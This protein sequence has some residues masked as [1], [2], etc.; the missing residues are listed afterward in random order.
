MSAL[1]S[2]DGSGFELL[3]RGRDGPRLLGRRLLTTTEPL[4]PLPWERQDGESAAAYKIFRV[5]LTLGWG[6][7]LEACAAEA[8]RSYEHV[9]RTARDHR[10]GDR[11]DAYESHLLQQ[12]AAQWIERCLRAFE[13][14]ASLLRLGRAKIAEA[15]KPAKDGG[16][17]FESAKVGD[18]VRLMDVVLRQSRL[19]YGD[20]YKTL[21]AVA[22]EEGEGPDGDE[23]TERF[24]R[25]P[26]S[27]RD[28]LLEDMRLRMADRAH[29]RSGHDDD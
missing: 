13:Q 28:Q 10:W 18:L 9:R 27:A 6:R 7:T 29:A 19:L 14:D 25:L 5:Y 3:A 17:N 12:V 11:V 23:D 4:A 26:K 22:V 2:C 1:R 21:A 24:K 15:L 20:P 8:K 16:I